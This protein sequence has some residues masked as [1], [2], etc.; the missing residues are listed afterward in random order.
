MLSSMRIPCF[1]F[2]LV[3]AVLPVIVV[4]GQVPENKEL[5]REIETLRQEW[6][7][8][9]AAAAVIK[10]GNVVYLNGFGFRDLEKERPFTPDTLVRVASTTKSFTAALVGTFVDEGKVDWR[11]PVRRYYPEFQMY[12]PTATSQTTFEDMLSHR[13]GLPVQE[14]L[15]AMGVGRVLEG[16]PRGYRENLLRRLRFF[17]PSKPF[18]SQWQ[19]QDNVYTCAGGILEW[20]SNSNYES[21]VSERL[22]TPLQM[23]A[24]TFSIHKAQQSGD[25]AQCYAK[26]G[27]KVVQMDHIDVSYIAPAGGL[28][29]NV[30]DMIRWVQFNIDQGRYKGKQ[31]V[32]KDSMSWIHAA[33]MVWNSESASKH[34]QSG[35]MSYAHGWV[36]IQH[37]GK[38]VLI[39]GGSFNGHRTTML[40]MPEKQIG[41]VVVCNLNLT[42]FDYLAARILLDHYLGIESGEKWNALMK[43]LDQKSKT[44]AKDEA[45]RFADGRY[46]ENRPAHLLSSYVGTYSHP[47]YGEFVV[48]EKGNELI[49]T[50]DNR[51]F[52]LKPYDGEVFESRFQSTENSLL[53]MKFE[54]RADA[55]GNVVA[56]YIPLVPDLTPQRFVRH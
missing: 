46:L 14:N 53:P 22:L 8:P 12:D 11:E 19:Y 30:K 16:S 35:E 33:H 24:S 52:T 37:H 42:R 48:K 26:N 7:V 6:H 17:E 51:S 20:I 21:L 34:F 28:Y 43:T 39:H 32:S 36:R 9:G 47:G 44:A 56:V 55:D 10:D 4:W 54:F 18:R 23:S 50:F 49:Q 2:F 27:D 40:F 45:K 31:I 1:C 13:T 25:L 41:V 5:N 3:F 29:S 15:L 38:L